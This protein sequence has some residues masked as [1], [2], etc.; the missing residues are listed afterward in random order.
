MRIDTQSKNLPTTAVV[1][2]GLAAVLVTTTLISWPALSGP[3][4]FDDFP[5]LEHLAELN[6]H[7]DWT[8]LANFASS[9]RGEPGRPLSMLSFVINDYDWPSSPWAFKYTNLMIHLLIG[10]VIF[11]F[12]RTLSNAIAT[13]DRSNIA[14]LVTTAAWLLH[15]MQLSTS[16]LVVQRMAQLS[17]LF[18]LSGLWGYVVLVKTSRNTATSITAVFVLGLGTILATLC[19]E[20]GALAPLLAIV[21]NITLLRQQ[22]RQIPSTP[23]RILL[24][25]SAL[26]VVILAVA[27]ATKWDALTGFGNRPFNLT[28]RLLS[29]SRALCDYLFNILIPNL[30]GGGIF[31]DDFAVSRS[32]LDPWTTL[33][34]VLVIL[35]LA[36][37]AL[38]TT[39]R[40]PLFSFA[41]LWFFAGHLLESTVFP[42]EIYFE[43]RNYMP[44]IGVLFSL[45]TW[46]TQA[47]FK[48]RRW[49]LPAAWVWIAFATFLTMVQ[50]PVWG[51][52]RA[53]V[54]VWAIEHP[55]SPR[56]IQ[57]K[58]G[59]LYENGH[60]LDAA[61]VLLG[62]YERGVRG[63]DFPIQVL[64]LACLEKDA[65]LATR[66]RRLIPDALSSGEYARALP[67][68]LGKLRTRVQDR[69]CPNQVSESDWLGMSERL[70][71]NPKYSQ[72]EAAAYIHIERSYYY[73]FHLDLNMTMV[74]LESAWQSNPTPQL[75][76]MIAVTLASA[77]LYRDAEAWAERALEYR[78]RGIRGFFSQDDVKSRK[79]LKAVREAQHK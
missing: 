67:I 21:A 24:V 40:R 47:P 34:A 49:V 50:A 4:L 35:A 72:G 14:A 44:M 17:V 22:L 28:E 30:R 53:L 6:G 60:R 5:N 41:I 12:S 15:P 39:K 42:L 16:M 46:I 3:F 13:D 61:S 32:I 29:E 52:K 38:L 10:V 74:E 31:H 1:A 18:S 58:A 45:A 73:R 25:G 56:A 78:V 2:L 36:I 8:S 71:E 33:P 75:A 64:F 79:V 59:D 20:T 76:Q 27:I 48:V 9:Y 63:S 69:D 26:P 77:G 43:H 7:L 55:R 23:R 19:K 70:L 68:T 62:A 65:D 54:T 57:Q 51:N 11:G 66:A 37:S